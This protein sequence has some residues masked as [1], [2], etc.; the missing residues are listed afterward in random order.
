MK[1]FWLVLCVVFLG[2]CAPS[3]AE[4]ENDDIKVLDT[5][6]VTAGR[7]AEKPEDVTSNITVFDED[8]IGQSSAHDLGGLL[9]EQGFMIREYPNSI[10]VVDIRGFKTD[11]YDSELE[12][13]VL[14]LV[15]GV[16]SGTGVLNKINID[17]VERIEIIRGPGSVQYGASAMGGVIN[18]ITK[19]GRGKPSVYVEQTTGSWDFSKISAGASGRADDV[20]FSL[21]AST[22]TQGDYQTA[23]GDT[24]YN[25]GFTSKERYSLNTG[26]TFLPKHRVGICYSGY[27][28]ENVGSPGYFSDIDR[29]NT[30]TLS[31]KDKTD[32]DYTGQME[33]GFLSWDLKYYYGENK[34]N[35]DTANNFP[36]D[37]QQGSQGQI[38]ADWGRVRATTG[39][40]WTHYK[41]ST[42][43]ENLAAFI[44][45]KTQLL[46]ERLVLSAAVRQDNYDMDGSDTKRTDDSNVTPSVGFAYKITGELKIRANYAEGFKVPTPEQLFRYNDYG[47][48]GILEGNPDLKPEKSKTW[49]CGLDVNHGAL[50]SGIT[51]FHTAFEDQIAYVSPM[52]G[53]WTYENLSGATLAGM[54]GNLRFDLGVMFDWDFELA[55][56]TSFTHLIEYTNDET[57]E[58]LFYTPDWR[59]SFGLSFA[60]RDQGFVSKLNFSYLSDQRIKDNEG[61][62]ANELDGFTVADLTVSK[63]LF[64]MGKAGEISLKA[65]I[66]NL[67]N[68]NY[69]LVQ[70]YPSP[71]RSF[72]M[73]LRYDY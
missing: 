62:G 26:W 41:K 24:Y 11:L 21:S 25:T 32:L 31:K 48:M 9:Q 55:P 15:D 58:D 4:K 13:Y 73:S 8:L 19:K 45:T 20:D 49:E 12:G 35:S 3:W 57:D 16:R 52:A 56:Y 70:G 60:M 18:V 50:S 65:D 22:E 5:L 38:T 23:Q 2:L 47:S 36:K 34:R 63:T 51:Y 33:N 46:N 61:T 17:N 29:T 10:V 68:E 14:I 39:L 30:I 1:R 53:Y 64:S 69:A 6:V 54:E 43:Y 66:R 71:G 37:K 7:V 59:A 40:D 42:T 27:K 28:A 44:L 72:Y 67:F